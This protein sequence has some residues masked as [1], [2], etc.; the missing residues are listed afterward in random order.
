[1][2]TKE[3]KDISPSVLKEMAKRE[4]GKRS[5][6][7]FIK[8]TKPDYSMDAHINNQ[9]IHKQIIEKFEA[10]E[11]GDIKRLMVFI[12]PRIGKSEI[13]SIRFPAWCLGRKPERNIAIC[14]YSASLANDFGLKCRNVFT[15]N[16]FKN[17]FEEREMDKAKGE[18]GDWKTKQWWW[19]YSVWV[20]WALSWKWFDIIIIDD[21]IKN[22]EEADS[23]AV[24]KMVND[25]YSSTCYTRLQSQNSAIILMMTRWSNDD[26]AG[27]LL[28][29]MKED[30]DADQWDV[31]TIPAMDEEGN[32]IIWPGKWDE[33]YL[34][35][36][37]SNVNKK[38][39]AAL[40]MQDPINSSQTI[41]NINDI[42]YFINSQFDEVNKHTPTYINKDDMRCIIYIDPAF[43]SSANSDDAVWVLI[44]K[45]KITGNYYIL[46]LVVQISAPT[47][48]Y[49]N[50]LAMYDE[51]IMD[52]FKIE[53]IYI[54]DVK[55]NRSQTEF[56]KHFKSF[57]K[58]KD[59]YITINEHLQKA[60]K[61]DRIRFT[62]EPI[63][64][65]NS[66]YLNKNYK[67]ISLLTSIY[68]QLQKFPFGRKDDIIDAITWWITVIDTFKRDE[69]KEEE[70]KKKVLSKRF[71][72]LPD[73]WYTKEW[74]I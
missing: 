35:K 24:K 32:Y 37:M 18:S 38:D 11:R 57:L 56:I 9:K 64:S 16:E 67:D 53:S 10:V 61:E 27:D 7:Y 55:L 51:G 43:S 41:F 69:K 70:K 26:L 34:K 65:L 62:L 4:L 1:M 72:K 60:K 31:L 68:Q 28:E 15:S 20:G 59:R 50:I 21:P 6:E 8:Y 48:L 49:M 22:R 63:I 13:A 3:K 23:V 58:K 14:S 2:E 54:E 5:L 52:W 46:N 33:W 40:Y 73:G 71:K 17:I 66:L 74:F 25:W 12:R 42:R 36:E 44:G 29:K 47:S 19:L 45:H 30:K 39:W